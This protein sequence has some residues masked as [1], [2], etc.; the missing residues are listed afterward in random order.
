MANYQLPP[1]K[2]EKKFEEFVCDL[3][4]EIEST[5][6][7]ENTEYQQ[8]GVTGQSQKGIDIFSPKTG[9]VIQCK[10]KDLRKQ[11]T[12]IRK[13]LIT[14]MEDD[15]RQSA[16]L[17]L[18]IKRF[19]LVST[20][21]D[22]AVI[23]E[24]AATLQKALDTPYIIY[25]WGWDTL[26]KYAEQHLSI[27]KKYFPK[28]VPKLPKQPKKPDVELPDGALGKDLF[29]Y[30]YITRLSR[31]YGDW[32]Q[33]QLDEEDRGEK[34]NWASHNKSLMNRYK[35]SGIKYIP[36]NQFED[37]AVYLQGRI[38]KTKFGRYRKANGL[39]NY[40]TFEDFVKGVE[41]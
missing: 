8:F 2:N 29:K 34:F 26:S 3:F 28:F 7:Y 40:S 30:N 37:L 16:G 39:K 15:V 41:V 22:D 18:N 10:L 23:Q 4:N 6:S 24:H 5:D 27:I 25:Y 21:R 32:K 19:Y 38:D 12:A 17:K 11:D 1:L 9:T 33:L 35:A 14:D 20:Y 36:V 31:R 13:Q